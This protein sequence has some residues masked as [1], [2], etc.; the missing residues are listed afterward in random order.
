MVL[1]EYTP[2]SPLT[3]PA[4]RGRFG[5]NGALSTSA[6]APVLD[7]SVPTVRPKPAKE[8]RPERWVL[9]SV[10]AKPARMDELRGNAHD[11][12]LARF[13]SH[14]LTLGTREALELAVRSAVEV[15]PGANHAYFLRLRGD[16]A[17]GFDWLE[18]EMTNSDGPEGEGGPRR[19]S[20]G[21]PLAEG[22]IGWAARSGV[23]VVERDASLHT[24]YSRQHEQSLLGRSP[25]MCLPV[26]PSGAMAAL[27]PAEQLSG[28][29]VLC[30]LSAPHASLPSARE[31]A[32]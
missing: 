32:L 6:S 7:R 8:P 21:V 4:E 27:P 26:Q 11:E 18:L 17:E 1:L 29:F 10:R 5:S 3:N 12:S 9:P 23:A 22:V 25:V 14:A 30:A 13:V 2:S 28:V 15:L 16:E 19:Q 24:A 20:R 31:V